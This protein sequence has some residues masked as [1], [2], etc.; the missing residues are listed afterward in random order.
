MIKEVLYI[1]LGMLILASL[2]TSWLLYSELYPSQEILKANYTQLVRQPSYSGDLQFSPNMRFSKNEISYNIGNGCPEQKRENMVLAF[3]YLENITGILS[4]QESSPADINITCGEEYKQEDM[5]VAGE[6]GPE[7]I[8]T[9]ESIYSV[10]KKGKIL[11]LYSE[12]CSYN[13]ELHELLHVFGFNHSTNKNSIMYPATAC[14]QVVTSDITNELKRLYSIP[15]LP[16]LYFGEVN[17]IKKGNYLNLNFTVKNQGLT[18]A[19]DT[20]V[21]LY[22]DNKLVRNFSLGNID[23]DITKI[24]WIENLRI[25][26]GTESIKITIKDGKELDES[27]NNADLTFSH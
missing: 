1:I 5:Y 2:Y 16:D 11:L 27:N 10:I 13:V 15:S 26:S 22:A 14:G 3:N 8:K 24:S 18:E 9:N 23:V 19:K 7:S 20:E 4:F 12:A 21:I 17:A 6:G 25:S